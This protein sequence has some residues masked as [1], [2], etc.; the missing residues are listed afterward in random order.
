MAIRIHQHSRMLKKPVFL[1]FRLQRLPER[2]AVIGEHEA[3]HGPEKHMTDWVICRPAS[4]TGS[5][6]ALNMLIIL[7]FS[8]PTGRF[9]MRTVGRH[10]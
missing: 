7:L 6:T 3:D 2:R 1:I 4:G 5:T 9:S 10:G 8:I